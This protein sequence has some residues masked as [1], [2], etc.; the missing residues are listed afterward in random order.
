[1]GEETNCLFGD[2]YFSAYHTAPGREEGDS[3]ELT[4]NSMVAWET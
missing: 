1:M 4:K 3:L 2:I